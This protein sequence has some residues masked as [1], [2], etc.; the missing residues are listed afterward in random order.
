MIYSSLANN[1][2]RAESPLQNAMIKSSSIAKEDE[3][4]NNKRSFS[5]KR[6]AEK[7]FQWLLPFGELNAQNI[8]AIL[9][10]STMRLNPE[11]NLRKWSIVGQGIGPKN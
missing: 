8:V 6:R 10:A 4:R 2:K 1:T 5:T 9:T 3:K 11:Q 7:G